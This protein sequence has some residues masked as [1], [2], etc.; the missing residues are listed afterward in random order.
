MQ[1]VV[2]KATEEAVLWTAWLSLCKQMLS[3]CKARSHCRTTTLGDIICHRKG[4]RDLFAFKM[5]S[6][7]QGSS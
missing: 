3:P 7:K 2:E 5:A 4:G 1:E 6:L